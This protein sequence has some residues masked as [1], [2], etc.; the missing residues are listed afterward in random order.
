MGAAGWRCSGRGE[1]E[2]AAW[3]APQSTASA[4][5]GSSVAAPRPGEPNSDIPSMRAPLADDPSA[6]LSGVIP[7]GDISMWPCDDTRVVS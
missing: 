6:L 4:G 7:S 1:G 5:E 2:D 3:S